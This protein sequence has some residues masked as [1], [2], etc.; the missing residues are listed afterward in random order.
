MKRRTEQEKK[1][2]KILGNKYFQTSRFSLPENKWDKKQTFIFFVYVLSS[3]QSENYA[4]RKS[5]DNTDKKFRAKIGRY[6]TVFSK[7]W[8]K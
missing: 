1:R 8:E 5:S 6:E 3:R 4:K 7:M 2:K